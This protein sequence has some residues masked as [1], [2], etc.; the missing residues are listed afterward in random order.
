MSKLGKGQSTQ[1][2]KSTI[3]THHIVFAPFHRHSGRAHFR[4]ENSLWSESR[5]W[6]GSLLHFTLSQFSLSSCD[7]MKTS[8]S[9]ALSSFFLL[10]SW[11]FFFL[12]R[13]QY[14]L[15][16]TA[17]F[18]SSINVSQHQ[19]ATRICA[20]LQHIKAVTEPRL[21]AERFAWRQKF[22]ALPFSQVSLL[23][24]QLFT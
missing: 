4:I 20:I 1:Q 5:L 10:K 17:A 8:L 9:P 22:R 3:S 11:P 24:S 18:P 15:A 23:L 7:V 6:V 21:K 12:R 19:S 16:L 14:A 13:T 2:K